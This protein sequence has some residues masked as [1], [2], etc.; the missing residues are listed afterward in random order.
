MLN[1]TKRHW[2]MNG[3]I[4]GALMFT[5]AAERGRA[6]DRTRPTRP[7]NLRA[8]QITSSSASLAWNPSTDNSGSFT[9]IL[10]ELTTAQSQAIPHT[11]TSYT[12][13][14]LLPA[15]TYRFVVFARDAAGNQS[16]NSNTLT[17]NTLAGPPPATPTN[18]RVVTPGLNSVSLAWDSV[19]SATGYHVSV[20]GTTYATGSAQPSYVA[21]GLI[22]GTSYQFA[23]RAQNSSGVSSWSA[24]VSATTLTDSSPPTTP[25][26]SGSGIS[27]GVV[28]LSWT[29]SFDDLSLVGYNV[30]VNGNPARS[31]LPVQS[32]P[33]TVTIHNLRAATTYAFTVKAYDS[34]GNFSAASPVLTLTTPTGADTIPPAAPQN[35]QAIQHWG[36]GISSVGLGW[37]WS[38]D[39]V[40]TMAYEI[41]M[42]NVLVGEVLYDVHYPGVDTSLIV[43][44]IPPGTT[45]TFSVRARDEAGNTSAP[46]NLITVTMSPSSD[47]TPPTAPLLISGS[48]AP[49]CGFLDFTWHNSADNVDAISDLEYEIYEDGLLRGVWRTEVFEAS[50]GR[51]R[52]HLRALDRSGNRSAPSNEIVLDSGLS[53]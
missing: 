18:L 42:D 49:G 45:R 50:F 33:R 40:G 38:A 37:N 46:S 32:S 25:F 34:T 4:V 39:N 52:F 51:H 13:T 16:L 27:P 28:Q 1:F 3:L 44:N 43:R 11:Q 9:Y 8:T 20:N 24:P 12:W 19:S 48:T 26:V 35:L 22:P 2:V 6:A 36:N 17:L 23:V 10:Q 41:Y 47:V 31:M 7:T 30:Y 15:R 53:C 5:F 21:S 14:G 29:E